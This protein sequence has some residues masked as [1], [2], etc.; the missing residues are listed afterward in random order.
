MKLNSILKDKRFRY[1]SVSVVFTAV[2][3]ALVVLLNA[4]ASLIA[5]GL[6]L[7]VDM[8]SSQLYSLSDTS[9]ELIGELD[10]DGKVQMIFL[11]EKDKIESN[12]SSY[13]GGAYLKEIHELALDYEAEFSDLIEIKYVN[14]YT[15]PGMLQ[16]YIDQGLTMSPT[17]VIFDNGQGIF[18]IIG[19][20]SFLAFDSGSSSTDPAGFYGE[21]KI[22]ATVLA[23]C[24]EKVTAYVTEGHGEA[25]LSESFINVLESCGFVLKTVNLETL[26]LDQI[27]EDEPRLVIVNNPKTDLKGIEAGSRSEIDKINKIL[28]G[29]YDKTTNNPT[30]GNL[31]I[32]GEPGTELPNVNSLLLRWGMQMNTATSDMVNETPDNVFGDAETQKILPLYETASSSIGSSLTSKLRTKSNFKVAMDG[33]GTIDISD[34]SASGNIYTSAVLKSS[35][36]DAVLAIAQNQTI[37]ESVISKV[38]YVMVCAD[39]SIIT[40][41]YLLPTDY[42]NEALMTNICRA[43]VNE[44]EPSPETALIEYK[45]YIVE[46]NVQGVS[47]AGKQAFLIFM[48]VIV[49]VVILAGGIVVYVRRRNK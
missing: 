19:Y 10:F 21:H 18:K 29:S 34:V 2:I 45:D 24:S 42:A 17:S 43:M 47:S 4:V 9:R 32:F 46:T 14:M 28:D 12:G 15:N 37:V 38:N 36:G 1:G 41:K 35:Y 44:T 7:Y 23:L 3:V 27:I 11:Q 39:S 33:T 49:P 8:T 26:T 25:A 30:F 48:A 13:E 6:H 16:K 5:G 20:K 40:D 31:M 22:T